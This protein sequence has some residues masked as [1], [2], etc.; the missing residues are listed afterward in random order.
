[1]D[2]F[3]KTEL[4][5][6]MLIGKIVMF[7]GVSGTIVTVLFDRIA[8]RVGQGAIMG[9]MQVMGLIAFITLGLFGLYA[10]V[11]LNDTIKPMIKKYLEN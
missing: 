7:V 1:M 10:D 8:G 2:G 3:K 9:P 11:F 6:F 4:A 5:V